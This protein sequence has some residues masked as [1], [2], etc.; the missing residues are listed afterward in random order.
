MPAAM[1]RLAAVGSWSGWNEDNRRWFDARLVSKAL[2]D[3]E[4]RPLLSRILFCCLPDDVFAVFVR[5]R[6]AACLLVIAGMR[7]VS[8]GHRGPRSSL[9]SG[10]SRGSALMLRALFLAVWAWLSVPVA[11]ESEV[12]TR[13]VVTVGPRQRHAGKRGCRHKQAQGTMV[14]RPGAVDVLQNLHS[15]PPDFLQTRYK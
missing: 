14:G 7:H 11:T 4:Q 15:G 3:H 2:E 1:S 12:G 5:L 9:S 8:R 10:P 6:I 13:H